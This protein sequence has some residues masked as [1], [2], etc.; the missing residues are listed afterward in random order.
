MG[1]SSDMRQTICNSVRRMDGNH[2]RCMY[3]FLEGMGK[4]QP[5]EADA[6]EDIIKT[7]IRTAPKIPK[8]YQLTAEEFQTI[9]D[10]ASDDYYL[11]SYGFCLGFHRGQQ[12]IMEE[13]QGILEEM[14]RIKS[15]EYLDLVKRFAHKLGEN[16]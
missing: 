8:D 4:I 1:K 11:I 7:A 3:A 14:E 12:A 10:A 6:G 5:K 9:A 2:L 16:E 13:H 15:P